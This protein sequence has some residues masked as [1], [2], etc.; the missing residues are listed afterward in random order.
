MHSNEQCTSCYYLLLPMWSHAGCRLTGFLLGWGPMPTRIS[1]MLRNCCT[2]SLCEG[3]EQWHKRQG[4]VQCISQ[5]LPLD[6]SAAEHGSRCDKLQC[7]GI[8]CLY[9]RP[10][11]I[12]FREWGGREPD[13]E[14]EKVL[15]SCWSQGVQGSVSKHVCLH[16]CAHGC[17][18]LPI[19]QKML[20]WPAVTAKS[21][22][23]PPSFSVILFAQSFHFPASPPSCLPM[24]SNSV[25]NFILYFCQSLHFPVT[26]THSLVNPPLFHALYIL[27]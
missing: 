25:T 24:H 17:F 12:S 14:R 15:I 3:Q 27:I 18:V 13:T 21:L 7:A 2:K 20:R 26:S 1:C 23:L 5:A 11:F 8:I 22:S 19:P 10:D 16:R 9:F 6:A 4:S